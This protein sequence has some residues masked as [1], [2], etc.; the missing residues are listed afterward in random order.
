[1][2]SKNK[3]HMFTVYCNIVCLSVVCLR[4][5]NESSTRSFDRNARPRVYILLAAV[6][7]WCYNGVYERWS[8]LQM[9]RISAF[10]LSNGR[11]FPRGDNH[12]AI[13][14]LHFRKAYIACSSKRLKSGIHF[15]AQ[16]KIGPDLSTASCFLAFYWTKEMKQFSWT[17][18]AGV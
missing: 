3:L 16:K 13:F 7:A 17:K 12:I 6:W 10:V 1:M 14:H 15:S 9:S 5:K 18:T 11:I 2:S 4:D 8:L